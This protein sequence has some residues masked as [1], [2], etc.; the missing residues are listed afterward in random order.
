[1]RIPRFYFAELTADMTAITLPDSVHRHAVQVL[2]LKKGDLIRIFNG[3]GLECE[4]RLTDIQKR[5]SQAE[6]IARGEYDNQSPLK[7]VLLQGVSRGERMDYAIQKAV[8]LGVSEIIPVITARCNMPLQGNRGDKKMQHWLGVIVSACEQSGR[9]D[10]PLLHDVIS[11]SE[12]LELN[13]TQARIILDPEAD[14]SLHQLD[15]VRSVTLLIGPEGGFSDEE[16]E[17]AKTAG[18]QAVQ[19][20]PRILRTETASTAA[21]AVMQSMWGDL[22]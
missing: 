8:E 3:K 12:A 18:Y 13:T 4:A 7:T 5:Q 20:G 11:F 9:N 21:L 1:M 2:R 17:Q 22:R 16:V 14:K 15:A 10:M 6:V 19:F